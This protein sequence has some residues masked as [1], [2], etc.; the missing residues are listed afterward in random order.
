MQG[1][2]PGLAPLRGNSMEFKRSASA[3]A[4][5]R[6]AISE[7]QRELSK[8]VSRLAAIANKRIKRLEQANI[9]SPA[10]NNWRNSGAQKFGVVGHNQSYQSLQSEYWRVKNY[11]D[12][13]TSTVTGAKKVLSQIASNIGFSGKITNELASQYFRLAEKIKEY[14]KM[15][16]QSAKAL[17]YQ[18]IW[19][20]INEL[21]EISGEVLSENEDDIDE[22]Y[23][24]GKII[25]LMNTPQFQNR[26][27]DEVAKIAEQYSVEYANL[28]LQH[29]QLNVTI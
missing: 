12:S 20:E 18:Q 27:D 6:Q 29:L 10:L 9:N 28:L 16:G 2:S 24:I 4:K 13:A 7:K 5:T 26:V 22:V 19:H 25:S 23:D 1:L 21:V 15:A 11:L 14:Y 17:D 8:E 3:S